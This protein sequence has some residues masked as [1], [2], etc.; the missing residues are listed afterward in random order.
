MRQNGEREV[1]TRHIMDNS[2][3]SSYWNGLYFVPMLFLCVMFSLPLI[4]VPQN[5][6]IK[7]WEHRYDISSI[8]GDTINFGFGLSLLHT[9]YLMI[10]IKSI[11]KIHSVMTFHAF[12]WLYMANLVTLVLIPN[13]I[14]YLIWN[15]ALGHD[16][17]MPLN[18]LLSGSGFPANYI[19]LWMYHTKAIGKNNKRRQQFRAYMYYKC[20]NL[21]NQFLI[22]IPT[23]IAQALPSE[24]QWVMAIILPLH[25]EM[26]HHVSKHFLSKGPGLLDS[27]SKT[28]VLVKV[29]SNYSVHVALAIGRQMTIFTSCCIL[30]VDF[31]FN[32][33]SAYKILKLH[34][35]IV[36]DH[37]ENQKRL[38]KKNEELRML[39]L[40]EIIEMMVP[41]AYIITHLI[42]Y[43]GPNAE[44]FNMMLHYHTKQL[45]VP[46]MLMFLIDFSSGILGGIMLVTCSINLLRE[47][48]GVIKAFGPIIT[49]QISRD[50]Y[51]VS[52][53]NSR[54]HM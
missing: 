30:M 31:T 22:I 27:A 25:R 54:H 52:F 36:P 1:A 35:K 8:I 3:N 43:Y 38:I 50:L 40:I 41:I 42:A 14:A 23:V 11:L 12:T 9:F 26:N 34:N 49:L 18:G 44:L 13:L 37:L 4:L 20:W 7:F 51:N 29:N 28:A 16:S 17:V 6:D 19:A 15:L 48:C 2:S 32:L 53:E 24:F 45:V 47:G 46:V 39:C 5:D 33:R 10:E 21:L